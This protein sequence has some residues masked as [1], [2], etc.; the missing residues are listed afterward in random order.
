MEMRFKFVYGLMSLAILTAGAPLAN[1]GSR[2]GNLQPFTTDGCTG[3]PDGTLSNPTQWQICCVRHDL[4]YWAGGTKAERI[5]ADRELRACVAAT[6]AVETAD[7]MFAGVRIGGSPY[8]P[9]A[10]HWGYGWTDCRGYSAL[11]N[12]E[13]ELV[14]SMTPSDLDSVPIQKGF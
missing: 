12:E 9:T 6:G 8:L 10:W 14:Q 4:L 1:A 13:F 2:H 5:A 11:S 3:F 7:L